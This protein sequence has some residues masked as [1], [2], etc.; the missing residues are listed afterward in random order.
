M[1]DDD[2]KLLQR[3]AEQGAEDAFTELVRRHLNLV[4]AAARRVTGNDELARDAAQEV[5]TDLARKARRLRPGTILAGWLHRAACHSAA[6]LVRGHAR[7]AE[8]ERKAMEPHLLPGGEADEPGLMEAML[9]MLDE[10]LGQLPGA[11]RDAVV[12]R[13]LAGKSLAEVGAALGMSE[14]AA[15]KRVS[16]AMDRLRDHFRRR[17]VATG[18]WTVA[19]A[20]GMAGAQAA[21]S[22]MVV[23]VATA[24]L[25]S[26]GA[27]GGL[28]CLLNSLTN[29]KTTCAITAIAIATAVTT[30]T[31]AHKKI[32]RL[33]YENQNLRAEL[34]GD[35]G[36]GMVA[37]GPNGKFAGVVVAG[38]SV[39]DEHAE[40]LR[41]RGEVALL[42]Q[43]LADARQNAQQATSPNSPGNGVTSTKTER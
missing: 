19:A 42:Q 29:M 41:L 18:V 39:N 12:L 23:T 35:T 10:A 13:F 8:R 20:L 22:D 37:T 21:P 2:K 30:A 5:F 40:L 25:A 9:P 27:N 6:K 3:Y 34:M 32:H 33:E 15:Q 7:R 1:N 24:S 26:A 31:V 4:W 11:D 38:N 14:D 36:N 16:R 43:N 28:A 17:G